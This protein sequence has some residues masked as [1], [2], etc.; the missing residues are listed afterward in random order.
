M[1]APAGRA[2]S[3]AKQSNAKPSKTALLTFRLALR[4]RT[5]FF[6]HFASS[7]P[8]SLGLLPFCER[9]VST[10]RRGLLR[11]VFITAGRDFGLDTAP[12]PC[13]PN[14]VSRL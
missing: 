1:S 4:A 3:K 8:A 13:P 7:R 2:L 12:R 14:N 10:N 9:R 5:S 6:S 11:G